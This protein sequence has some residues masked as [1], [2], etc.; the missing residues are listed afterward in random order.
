MAEV[1]ASHYL[2]AFEADPEADD[3]QAVRAKAGEMLARAG[4]RA[5]S[6]GAPEEGKRYYEQAAALADE[7][8]AEAALL[9]QAGR[10]A[11]QA[12]RAA[13]ARE[14]LERA[15]ALYRDAG[16]TQAAARASAALADVDLA[17]GRLDEAAAR[18]E[19]AVEQLEQGTPSAAL[20]AALAQ[21]GRMRVLSGHW[22]EAAAPSSRHSLWPSGCSCPTCSSRP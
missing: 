14:R 9:E 18:L 10:L 15:L 12:N 6:L 16:E 11:V 4:E 22:E 2:A 20:A 7:P 5:A 1:L 17:E 3:A 8:L 19:Q 21:L 13:E